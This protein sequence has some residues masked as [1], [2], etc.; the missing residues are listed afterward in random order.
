MHPAKKS[1]LGNVHAYSDIKLHQNLLQALVLDDLVEVIGQQFLLIVAVRLHFAHV[2][3]ATLQTVQLS[4]QEFLHAQRELEKE[5]RRE[6]ALHVGDQVDLLDGLV[7]ARLLV[8]FLKKGQLLVV[9]CGN[10]YWRLC[11]FQKATDNCIY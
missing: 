8:Q 4:A 9:Y 10:L 3:I 5:G 7:E 6:N 2:P 1:S 11:Y